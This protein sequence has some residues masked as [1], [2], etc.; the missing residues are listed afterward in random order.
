MD[1]NSEHPDGSVQARVAL[2]LDRFNNVMLLPGVLDQILGH[3][4]RTWNLDGFRVELEGDPGKKDYPS[5]GVYFDLPFDILELRC[6]EH[7][8]NDGDPCPKCGRVAIEAGVQVTTGESR[9]ECRKCSHFFVQ[10]Y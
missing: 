6:R 3:L 9:W 7:D 1:L 10:G 8:W 5:A 2:D 4:Q